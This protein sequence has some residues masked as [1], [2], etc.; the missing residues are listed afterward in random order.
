M[1]RLD[2]WL[3]RL[4]ATASVRPDPLDAPL[5]DAEALR[6]LAAQACGAPH[7]CDTRKD[8]AQ[9][10]T[11]DAPAVTRGYGGDYEESRTYQPGDELRFMNWRLLAR[12][13][14]PFVKVFREERQPGGFVLIDRRASMRF[15]TR[16]RL[17]VTQAARVAAWCAFRWQ[18]R[19]VAIGGLLLEQPLRW[20][21]QT[22][23]PWCAAVLRRATEP[24]IRTQAVGADR[25]TRQPAAVDQ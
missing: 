17:K 3:H 9:R 4:R 15:G 24:R 10:A 1:G 5:L 6:E 16:R 23:H 20:F 18:R 12:T 11:G 7:E 25:A 13:G 2:R 8:V 14:V 19:R 21:P 22:Q